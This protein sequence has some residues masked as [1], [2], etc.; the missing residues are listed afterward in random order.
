M[1]E[2]NT[3]QLSQLDS[4]IRAM[5]ENGASQEDVVAYSNDYRQKYS[6]KKKDDTTNGTVKPL[7]SSDTKLASKSP[8]QSSVVDKIIN[9]QIHG[10]QNNT[11]KPLTEQQK[12]AGKNA[13]GQGTPI[14]P[15]KKAQTPEISAKKSAILKAVT[16]KDINYEQISSISNPNNTNYTEILASQKE[17]PKSDNTVTTNPALKEEQRQKQ[18]EQ[19]EF[20]KDREFKVNNPQANIRILETKDPVLLKDVADKASDFDEIRVAESFNTDS[21]ISKRFSKPSNDVPYKPFADYLEV[22]ELYTAN[23]MELYETAE[24]EADRDK[25]LQYF[26][27]RGKDNILNEFNNEQTAINYK[28]NL[29]KKKQETALNNLKQK[30]GE[31]INNVE[32]PQDDKDFID[33]VAAQNGLR[34]NYNQS[35][36]LLKSEKY[37]EVN[38]MIQ[39]R[40][41]RQ[42]EIDKDAKEDTWY[43]FT[44]EANKIQNVVMNTVYGLLNDIASLPRFV[45]GL[46]GG[47]KFNWTDRVA[48]A[49]QR[50]TD[51]GMA[52]FNTPTNLQRENV[53]DYAEVD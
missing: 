16:G 40:A 8:K 29:L 52:Y 15:E 51:A 41:N 34:E 36:D 31:D 48:D 3:D 37:S 2:L 6:V 28:Q 45:N 46:A 20:I 30:Y 49:T 38:K 12:I 7:T 9:F 32:I 22:S 33:I 26:K 17:V 42:V 19:T 11:F 47:D 1:A 18:V 10:V 27:D 23:P 39:E 53:Q 4:N 44:D 13:L 5:L 35:K 50:F 14:I 21:P 25:Q 43:K 24:K